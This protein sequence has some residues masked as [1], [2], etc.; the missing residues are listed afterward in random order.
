MLDF[1]ENYVF[2]IEKK[3]YNIPN[4]KYIT[5]FNTYVL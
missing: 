2:N 1:L 3:L 5:K 4:R